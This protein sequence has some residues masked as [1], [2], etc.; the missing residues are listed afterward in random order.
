MKPEAVQLLSSAGVFGPAIIVPI[1]LK[2]EYLVDTSTIG[3]IAGGFATAGFVSSYL[4]GRA[5]D[6]YGKRKILLFGL[7]LTV[8]ATLAQIV[9]LMFGG[10]EVF[11]F[12]RVLLGFCA[13]IF[14][15]ALLAYAY[16]ARGKMGKFSSWGAAG[17]GVGNIFVGV[18]GVMYEEAYLFCAGLLLLS[19]LFALRLPFP[20]E[21]GMPVPL[22]P[23]ELIRRNAPVYL[24][25]LIRHTGANMIWVTYPLFLVSIGAD[26]EW[27]G[28][29]YAVNAFGQFFIMNFLDRYDPTLLVAVGL[30]S[31]ALTFYAF[32]L[33]RSFWE[34]LPAQVL[35]AA[36]W[37]C[38]YVGSLRYVMDKNKEKATATGILS[39]VMNISGIVGP[40]LGGLAASLVDFK[41]TITIASLMA[42]VAFLIFLYEMKRSGEFYRL[43]ARSR[44]AP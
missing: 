42:A 38:L 37:S 15:A 24:S 6:V 27:V 13:G 8:I 10:F 17:W 1:I 31:S 23:V 33:A 20:K 18:F 19:F 40:V 7:A 39:S 28:V 3:L 25:M 21:V 12:V 16:E 4:F 14:P 11:S 22:F 5:S 36:A 2:E 41:G 43:R 30:V 26:L 29:I 32:L 35:L 34:I 9:S 44:G